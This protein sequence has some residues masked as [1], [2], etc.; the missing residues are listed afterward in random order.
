VT[1]AT[2]RD[3]GPSVVD[4]LLYLLGVAGMAASLTILFLGMRA[5]M[6]VG[7]YC[8]EGGALEIR[9]H[10]PDGVPLLMMLGIFGL[11]PAGGLIAWRG[12]RLG[13]G[14]ASLVI[15]AWPGLFL[16]LGFNFLQY[17][18]GAADGSGEMD[19]GW[20]IPGVLFILMGGIPLVGWI[21]A[22]LRGR[23]PGAAFMPSTPAR[24]W[25]PASGGA[26][27]SRT[28]NLRSST[29]SADGLRIEIDGSGSPTVW[30]WD[31]APAAPAADDLVSELER[32]TNLHAS[33]ALSDT[34]FDAAKA[35]LLRSGGS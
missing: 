33:G 18:T 30:R 13:A 11:F 4:V 5:V 28:L 8:A 22:A 19:L 21:L 29:G 3:G 9:V 26:F 27:G 20:L 1:P 32:L 7:G 31:G 16:S 10:C 14:Y 17:G 24:S 34:E 25:S 2:S 23:V 12:A 15:F 6:D 35:A